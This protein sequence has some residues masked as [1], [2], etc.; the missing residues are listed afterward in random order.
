MVERFEKVLLN[1]IIDFSESCTRQKRYQLKKSSTEEAPH[2]RLL[3]WFS[4][5][6]LNE[7]M[8]DFVPREL[9]RFQ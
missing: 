9:C 8:R 5:G 7:F 1:I 6:M 2:C 4:F 3:S